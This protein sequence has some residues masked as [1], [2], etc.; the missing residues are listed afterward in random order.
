VCHNPRWD[1]RVPE[2]TEDEHHNTHCS[3]K[4]N[5]ML[6]KTQSHVDYQLLPVVAVKFIGMMPPDTYIG[7]RY[8]TLEG[9]VNWYDKGTQPLKGKFVQTEA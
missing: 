8:S 4:M 6:S 5:T 1:P 7:Q 2:I 9:K 3:L